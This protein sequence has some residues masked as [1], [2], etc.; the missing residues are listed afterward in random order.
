M[1][2]PKRLRDRLAERE[3]NPSLEWCK[4]LSGTKLKFCGRIRRFKQY[5]GSFVDFPLSREIVLQSG[6]DVNDLQ[7]SVVLANVD[8]DY[9]N[10]AKYDKVQPYFTYDSLISAREMLFQQFLPVLGK[11][12]VIDEFE[13]LGKMMSVNTSP[14]FPWCMWFPD[15]KKLLIDH[16]LMLYWKEFQ[17]DVNRGVDRECIF[18]NTVKEELKPKNKIALN[19]VRVFTAAPWQHTLLG[20]RLWGS[21]NDRLMQA[22]VLGVKGDLETIPMTVGLNKFSRGWDDLYRRLLVH[23]HGYAFDISE[24]DSGCCRRLFEIVYELRRKCLAELNL[25]TKEVAWYLRNVLDTVVILGRGDLGLK[26]TGNC[27]GQVNTI[28]DNSLIHIL[29]WYYVFQQLAPKKVSLRDFRKHVVLFTCGDDSIM[30]VSEIVRPWFRP[31]RIGAIFHSAGMKFKFAS[32]FAQPIYDLDYCSMHFRRLDGVVVPYPVTAKVLSSL[33]F[34]NRVACLRTLLLRA[35]ALRLDS[36]YNDQLRSI[37]A[38]VITYCL[39]NIDMSER[40]TGRRGDTLTV[41]EI[42]RSYKTDREL[43]MLYLEKMES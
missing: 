43:E 42:M 39:R 33:V 40:P 23:S 14:G 5:K 17:F 37:L 2:Y 29:M 11:C 24:W 1:K 10:F 15:K 4:Y 19:K 9:I 35:I 8:A 22:C 3:E 31:D 18:Q 20:Y 36:Y 12:P 34:K 13:E 6:G 21:M 30:S 27:S 32:V 16:E 7:Y 38:N 41:D 26:E 28:T 25:V